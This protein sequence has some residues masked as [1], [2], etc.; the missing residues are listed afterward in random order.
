M[1]PRL[2]VL[3]ACAVLFLVGAVPTGAVYV[4]TLPTGA[5]VWLDG[6]YI[7]HSPVILDALTTGRHTVSLNRTGW[8]SQDVDVSV[9]AGTTALAS[10]ALTRT[11]AGV[12]GSDGSF[13]LRG[14]PVRS[15]MLD[16]NLLVPDKDGIFNVPSG[17]HQLVARTAIGQMTRNITIYP[18]MRTDIV[19]RSEEAA[20]HSAVVAP[21]SDY[22][23]GDAVRIDGAR[24]T[25][26][27]A[28][29]E[30]EAMLGATTYRYDGR[31]VNYD[32]APTRI[33]A[34]LYL[35]LELLKQLT[36]NDPKAK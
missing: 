13:T 7:G 22:L 31:N 5:D 11:A 15:L 32:A 16:G 3:A 19:L 9:V 23:P 18:D 36:A 14:I 8:T 24:V 33:G 10:V 35:P 20:Q 6:T 30:V 21:A 26:K 4:T 27:Y 2:A 12:R 29:H 28:R 17:T 34:A 25:I 1:F